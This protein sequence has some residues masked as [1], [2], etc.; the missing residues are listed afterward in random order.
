MALSFDHFDMI[1]ILTNHRSFDSLKFMYYIIHSPS[2]SFSLF[3][4]PLFIL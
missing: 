2:F 1:L 3:P 4:I